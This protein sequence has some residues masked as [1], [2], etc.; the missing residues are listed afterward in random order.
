MDF[1]SLR[2]KKKLTLGLLSKQML[3][4]P[5]YVNLAFQQASTVPWKCFN[6]N[7]SSCGVLHWNPCCQCAVG[8]SD[9]F[10]CR[11][12]VQIC[13]LLEFQMSQGWRLKRL[14][15]SKMKAHVFAEPQ[16]FSYLSSLVGRN[17]VYSHTSYREWKYTGSL[18]EIMISCK[19]FNTHLYPMISEKWCNTSYLK[20]KQHKLHVITVGQMH[21]C[22]GK[23]EPMYSKFTS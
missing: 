16:N 21:A 8:N 22:F 20:R 13:H 23:E 15:F 19:D 7:R 17:E 14:S 11:T 9:D 12:E 2:M 5:G 10:A 1:S 6:E 18:W 4:A 3:L